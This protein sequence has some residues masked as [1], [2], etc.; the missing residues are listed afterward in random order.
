MRLC[1]LKLLLGSLKLRLRSLKLRHN[2][3]RSWLEYIWRC[4]WLLICKIPFIGFRPSARVLNRRGII[5]LIILF[6]SSEVFAPSI[7]R[8]L[9]CLE[10]LLYGRISVTDGALAP[11]LGL[12]F[13]QVVDLIGD[14]VT[15]WCHQTSSFSM[16]RPSH[17]RLI[18]IIH[19]NVWLYS[20]ETF[21]P[22][23]LCY[24]HVIEVFLLRS[25]EWLITGI[26]IAPNSFVLL[27]KLS[28]SHIF[29]I[30]TLFPCE[31]GFFAIEELLLRTITNQFLSQLF[32]N[33]CI[34]SLMIDQVR[35]LL[36]PASIWDFV[37]NSS[38]LVE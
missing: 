7:L 5:L 31:H 15:V 28:R 36:T 22:A 23:I 6:I 2:R 9:V 32:F 27:E 13:V 4:E 26:Y 1:S 14:S 18:D 30:H 3:I 34:F 21:R 37:P 33:K 35:A 20:A 25:C 17:L 8:V 38:F 11:I 29:A 16:I 24:I 12:G 19:S 10:V